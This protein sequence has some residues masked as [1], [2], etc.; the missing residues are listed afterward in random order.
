MDVI[1]VLIQFKNYYK[2]TIISL[3]TFTYSY[4]NDKLMNSFRVDD[5][6][7]WGPSIE[8]C[9]DSAGSYAYFNHV[10]TDGGDG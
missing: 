1:S 9:P 4:V 8:L 6:R 2:K 3:Q 7:Q 5:L 10:A